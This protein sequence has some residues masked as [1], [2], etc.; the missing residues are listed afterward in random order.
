MG[1]VYYHHNIP[2]TCRAQ[3]PHRILFFLIRLLFEDSHAK[4]G[5]WFCLRTHTKKRGSPYQLHRPTFWG[6]RIAL[7]VETVQRRSPR[8]EICGMLSRAYLYNNKRY[9]EGYTDTY[10]HIGHLPL[11]C[12]WL[13]LRFARF[14]NVKNNALSKRL[15]HYVCPTRPA[16][17]LRRNLKAEKPH[18]TP[19]CIYFLGV[20]ATK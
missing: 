9:T 12:L 15:L 11:P 16:S 7:Q 2:N 17:A 18:F 1:F 8:K 4:D 19:I 20:D 3:L 5:K 10:S 6:S 13:E 14:Q